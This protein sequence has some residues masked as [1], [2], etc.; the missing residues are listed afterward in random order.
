VAQKTQAQLAEGEEDGDALDT[1]AS[2]INALLKS[3]QAFQPKKVRCAAVGVVSVGCIRGVVC[4]VCSC[5]VGS[6]RW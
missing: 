1:G 3:D 6:C 2:R 5:A 4:R